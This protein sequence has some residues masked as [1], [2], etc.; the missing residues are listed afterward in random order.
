MA[1]SIDSFVSITLL[2]Q[3]RAT[4]SQKKTVNPT[5]T[6]A[7]AT[8]DFPLYLSQ[9]ADLGALELV[10]WDKDLLKKDYLGEAALTMDQWFKDGE[11]LAFD[12]ERNFVRSCYRIRTCLTTALPAF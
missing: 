4:S 7:E 9:A 8:Y 11:A 6:A 10:V 2:D 3:R 12:H 1:D 5:W